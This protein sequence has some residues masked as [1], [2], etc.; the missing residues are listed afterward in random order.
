[1]SVLQ[2]NVLVLNRSWQPVS[3]TT[4]RHAVVQ[5][6]LDSARFVEP[7]SF[8]T[9]DFHEWIVHGSNEDGEDSERFI[10]G[11]NW[12]MPVPEVIVLRYHN[13]RNGFPIR[14]SRR[15]LLL[16][17]RFTCQYCGAQPPPSELTLDHVVP[18][19]RGGVS[20]WSNLVV[21]CRRCNLRKEN[22][23]PEEAGLRLLR[24]A[25]QPRWEELQISRLGS[26][27]PDSWR[28][29]LT[30]SRSRSGQERSG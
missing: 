5:V 12:R 9:Y 14:F 15:N 20:S 28:V 23:T 17:D 7:R 30:P 27:L 22:L 25:Y 19:S 1:M 2:E 4:V 10:H 11:C 18:R 29:F 21:A 16:R 26:R 8:A 3:V 24:P 6:Y 13:G